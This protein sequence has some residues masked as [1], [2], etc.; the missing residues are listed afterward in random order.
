MYVSL[1]LLDSNDDINDNE[2]FFHHDDGK[3]GFLQSCMYIRETCIIYHD[4][5][6]CKPMSFPEKKKLNHGIELN[7]AI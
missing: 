4:T 7:T 2:I 3:N 6:V 1:F 5:C